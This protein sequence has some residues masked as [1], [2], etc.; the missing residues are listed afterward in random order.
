MIFTD[1]TWSI[2]GSFETRF[3]SDWHHSRL[4]PA[5]NKCSILEDTIRYVE[6]L[7]HTPFANFL[8]KTG[9]RGGFWFMH[10]WP[11]ACTSQNIFQAAIQYFNSYWNKYHALII[12]RR[13]SASFR[14]TVHRMFD[15]TWKHFV[16]RSTGTCIWNLNTGEDSVL[17]ASRRKSRRKEK[18]GEQK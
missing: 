15:H 11:P 18:K 9:E 2:T 14:N 10:A 17:D 8:I 4:W 3:V 16:H 13:Q 1:S 5:Y 6:C 12:D 7:K